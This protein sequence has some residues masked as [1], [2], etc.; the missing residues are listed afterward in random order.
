MGQLPGTVV[1]AGAGDFWPHSIYN[2]KEKRESIVL[3]MCDSLGLS[4]RA[5]S[6]R[7]DLVGSCCIAKELLR[8]ER[9][10]VILKM[11][12]ERAG[13]GNVQLPSFGRSPL[14]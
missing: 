8:K 13:V 7:E 3:A 10:V 11:I 1:P 6:D 14:M 9:C 2:K 4:S 5:G 12:M